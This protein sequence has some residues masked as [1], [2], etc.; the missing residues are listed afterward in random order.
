[1]TERARYLGRVRDLA[2]QAAESWLDHRSELGF[3]LA[4]ADAEAV[5]ARAAADGSAARLPG[6]GMMAGAAEDF[7]LEIGTEELPAADV[8][9]AVANLSQR[10]PAWLDELR[11][12]HGGVRVAGTPRRLV[13]RVARLSSVQPDEARLIKGPPARIAFDAGGNPTKAAL[14]F[15]RSQGIDVARQTW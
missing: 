10:V 2:R 6:D 4:R 11:L 14:G 1:M 13:V 15:A 8:A 7:L 9:A 12:G 5:R 3:P